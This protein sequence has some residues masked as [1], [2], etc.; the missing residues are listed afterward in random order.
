MA[1]I[2]SRLAVVQALRAKT[3]LLFSDRYLLLTNTGVTLGLSAAGDFFQQRYE[4]LRS[5]QEKWDSVRTRN[6]LLSVVAVCPFVHYW[7][8][9]LDRFLPGRT[10]GIIMKKVFVDQMI[11]SPVCILSFLGITGYLEGL[12][13][14]KICHDVRTKGLALMKAE[15]IVWPP[16]QTLQFWLLP[17]RYRVLYDNVVCLCVDYYYYFVKYSQAWSGNNSNQNDDAVEVI[18]SHTAQSESVSPAEVLEGGVHERDLRRNEK[19][20][21]ICHAFFM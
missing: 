4:I 13:T 12:S 10:F 7:Y 18:D 3:R 14:Q 1:S 17:T 5:R 19:R 21:Y 11:M 8:I 9:Y 16:A 2:I 15:W 6:I 20:L